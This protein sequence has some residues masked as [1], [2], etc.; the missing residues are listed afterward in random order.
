MSLCWCRACWCVQVLQAQSLG[1]RVILP[2]Q[3]S[4]PLQGYVSSE[5]LTN[6]LPSPVP[7]MHVVVSGPERFNMQCT[8][9]LQDVGFTSEQWTVL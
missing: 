9:M 4:V 8:A 2:L 3:C 6:L 1:V 7:G 5:H